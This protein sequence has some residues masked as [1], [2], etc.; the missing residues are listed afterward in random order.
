MFKLMNPWMIL[1]VLAAIGTAGGVGYLKG[2]QH[3]K[4]EIESDIAREERIG[5]IAFANALSASASQIAKI[6][7]TNKTITQELE[8]EIRFEPVYIDCRHSDDTKRMLDAILTGSQPAE[9]FD[10]SILPE[11]NS[12]E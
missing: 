3:M 2:S 9:S 12:A 11:T 5:Q 1:G 7:V 6:R 10:R 8:R 4:N